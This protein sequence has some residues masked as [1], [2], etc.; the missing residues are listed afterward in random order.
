MCA[1]WLFV[2]SWKCSAICRPLLVRSK[3]TVRV[4]VMFW[5]SLI[6]PH[7]ILATKHK[8]SLTR[9]GRRRSFSEQFAFMSENLQLLCEAAGVKGETYLKVR[10]YKSQH[11]LLYSMISTSTDFPLLVVMWLTTVLQLFTTEDDQHLCFGRETLLF[12][13]LLRDKVD[14][15][16]TWV[17]E[18]DSACRSVSELLNEIICHE[19]YVV[20]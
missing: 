19:W 2:K 20:F 11:H 6:S 16:L 5:M 13:G 7:V 18:L 10:T 15:N 3:W 4:E 17:R 1:Y 9:T 12:S 14:I 8:C